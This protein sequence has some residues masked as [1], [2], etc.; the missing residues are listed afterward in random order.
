MLR[1][2]AH[3]NKTIEDV[4]N[5]K[6]QDSKFENINNTKDI[7]MKGTPRWLFFF[8]I[9]FVNFILFFCFCKQTYR[10]NELKDWCNTANNKLDI[11]FFF[12]EFR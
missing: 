1:S 5:N 11:A 2:T 3:H 4:S 8:S 6:K 12:F 10:L 7:S 9:F